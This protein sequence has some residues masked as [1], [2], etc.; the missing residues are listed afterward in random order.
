MA[1]LVSYFGWLYVG[2]VEDYDD[3]GKH[4][5]SQFLAEAEE[6][7][8]CIAFRKT[9]PRIGEKEK[10]RVL[11]KKSSLTKTS[12]KAVARKK[13][14]LDEDYRK[15]EQ[16]HN[17]AAHQSRRQS[18]EYR[19][20]EQ[21][22]DTSAHQSRRQ[23]EEYRSGE[24]GRDTAAHKS[25]RQ[26]DEYR[27]GEQ[28]RDTAAHQSLRQS[29][30]YRSAAH[31]SQR[32]SEE[33]RS[34]EQYR[35][36]AAHQSTR[37]VQ[38]KVA[39]MQKRRIGAVFDVQHFNETDYPAKQQDHLIPSLY[40]TG[41]KCPFCKAHCWKEERPGFCCEKGK[42]AIN[43]LETYSEDVKVLFDQKEFNEKICQFN[44]ALAMASVRI[45]EH[46]IPGFSPMVKL[47]GKAHHR[48]E[49]LQ[50]QHN[51]HFKGHFPY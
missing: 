32:E 3:Y 16:E 23:S 2:T 43:L 29:E 34:A 14:R 6:E 41:H 33:Y 10:T 21:G 15:Q 42:I 31:Q 48:I 47:Q 27:S 1:H 12:K 9:L 37:K 22:R 46:F 51:M 35:N 39:L 8:L 7:G 26:S 5:I 28:E 20:G 50:Q 13:A 49:T 18:E 24:Q 38:L 19:S 25:R 40:D 17:T 45:K 44:N 4:G 11:A 36:T 30:E